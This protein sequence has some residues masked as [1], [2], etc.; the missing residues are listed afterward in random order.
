MSKEMS[1]KY[2]GATSTWK[3]GMIKGK[4]PHEPM[5]VGLKGEKLFRNFLT[6]HEVLCPPVNE[7]V[8][9]KGDP[10]YDF[11]FRNEAGEE[12]KIDVKTSNTGRIMD[13]NL[14]VRG[15]HRGKPIPLTADY[16][17]SV[18]LTLGRVVGYQSREFVQS[19]KLT[20]SLV[21]GAEHKN[22]EVWEVDLLSDISLLLLLKKYQHGLVAEPKKPVVEKKPPV[23]TKKSYMELKLKN[24]MRANKL[25]RE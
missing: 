17:V 15:E 2:V 8:C 5:K 14:L 7:V 20:T 22:Y 11:I 21:P 3:K 23:L 9:A 1:D 25:L 18:S 12:I 16:Y 6:S 10:G 13:G 19:Q 24:L 4:D